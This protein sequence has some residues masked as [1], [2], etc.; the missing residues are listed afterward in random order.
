MLKKTCCTVIGKQ[1]PVNAQIFLE[2]Q[3]VIWKDSF[4]YLG[5][6]F[7]CNVSTEVD[8]GPVRKNIMLHVTTL[9]LK[10]EVLWNLLLCSLIS[11][12]YWRPAFD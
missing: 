9:F 2:Q 11:I 1:R 4:R 7:K 12:L 5:I 10:V 8:V 3:A 6:H